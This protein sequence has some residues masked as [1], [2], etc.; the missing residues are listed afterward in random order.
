MRVINAAAILLLVSL[1]VSCGNG[2]G[3]EGTNADTSSVAPKSAQAAVDSTVPGDSALR[4]HKVQLLCDDNPP[5]DETVTYEITDPAKEVS[6][7]LPQAKHRLVVPANSASAAGVTVELRTRT[8]AKRHVLHIK[9]TKGSIDESKLTMNYSFCTATGTER[10]ISRFDT[11]G[12]YLE[13][14]GGEDKG[15]RVENAPIGKQSS[16]PGPLVTSGYAVASN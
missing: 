16:G 5:R 1:T 2:G 6:I 13:D 15:D 7:E 10:A 8:T 14:R 3:K 4:Q 12:N 9:V 11:G